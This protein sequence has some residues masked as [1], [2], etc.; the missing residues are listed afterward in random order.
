MKL[1]L[2]TKI[3][4]F[5][6]CVLILVMSL[7]AYLN[8]KNL[9]SALLQEVTTGVD[10]MSE[11]I[12]RSSHHLMLE[13]DLPRVHQMIS[14]VGQQ[15]DIQVIRLINKKGRISFS[16]ND[17]ELGLFLDKKAEACTM[18][19]MDDG[20]PRTH[21]SRMN[22]S[23]LFTTRQGKHVMGL[24]KAIYNQESCY[25][26][27]CHYHPE[28]FKVL[29]VLDVVVS[30]DSTIELL[31]EYRN[32]KIALTVL[33]VVVISI[34]L[35][36]LA[37]TFI[38]HPVRLLLAHTQMVAKGELDNEVAIASG[39]EIGELAGAFNDMTC[40]LRKARLEL[41]EWGKN[42][43]AKVEERTCEIKRMQDHLL[44]SEKLASLGELVAGIAHELNNPLTGMLVFGNL[45]HD[46]QRLHP[47]LQ[48]DMVIIIQQTERCSKIVKGLLDFSRESCPQP[49]PTCLNNLIETTLTLIGHQSFFHNIVIRPELDASLPA[50]LIDPNQVEQVIINLM[51]NAS[52]AMPEGGIMA[53]ST[54]ITPDS[55]HVFV[56]VRDT[57][58]GIAEENLVKIFD[59][60]FSTKEKGTGLGLSLCYGIVENNRGRIEVESTVDVGTTFTLTFPL[61]NNEDRRD[62]SWPS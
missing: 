28:Q 1:R 21:T 40:N 22:S 16:T 33:L 14:E 59:P 51:I 37:L 49:V 9:E 38:N 39:D 19:H 24:A 26:A 27:S 53:I 60:F 25:T 58:C 6:N 41:E 34:C 56:K 44:R 15:K 29:G 42:L 17:S 20:E 46:D 57:G 35:Y 5:T 23:R 47:D 45:V 8:L 18:C 13:D 55:R 3:A 62:A 30:L 7:F 10:K 4:I 48:K 52:Q 43:E 32:K 54:G 2:I 31:N 50:T 11:T 12:I 36:L 61:L